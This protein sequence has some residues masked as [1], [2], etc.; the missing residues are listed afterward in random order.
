MFPYNLNSPIADLYP[1]AEAKLID[2]GMPR[3]ENVMLMDVEG[4]L[5]I[6]LRN[7]IENAIRYTPNGGKVDVSLFVKDGYAML[8]VQ[9]SGSGILEDKLT[10]VFEP[11]YRLS[12]NLESG[13]GLGL[14]ISLEISH[15]LGGEISLSN[16]P[17]GGLLFEYRQLLME[18]RK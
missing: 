18:P 10:Q 2:L 3:K 1:L 9:D 17:D 5:A 6:L 12:G 15:R 16:H 13:N 4:G 8:Q 11:F 7:A 14:A